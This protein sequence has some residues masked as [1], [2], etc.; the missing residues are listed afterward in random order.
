[1]IKVNT[2]LQLFATGEQLKMYLLWRLF[3]ELEETKRQKGKN[4]E[5]VHVK[6]RDFTGNVWMA[7]MA[8]GE[9]RAVVDRGGFRS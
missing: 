9:V 6:K 1:M 5:A 7:Y 2:A 8:A 3:K 4:M